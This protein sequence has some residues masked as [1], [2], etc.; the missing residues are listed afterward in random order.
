MSEF[1]LSDVERDD[2]RPAF[3]VRLETFGTR[4]AVVTEGGEAITYAELARRA[5]AAVKDVGRGRRLIALEARNHLD[6]LA[7]YLGALRAGHPLILTS[8]EAD[9]DRIYK[10]FQP[11]VRIVQDGETWRARPTRARAVDVHPDLTLLLSTSGTTGSAKLVRISGV[12]LDSNAD[13]IAEY[14]RLT[15]ADRA[16]TTLPMTYSYGLSVINSH[17]AVGA[18]IILTGTSVTDPDF[19]KLANTHE[20][21]SLAGVPHTY[22][23]LERTGFLNRTPGSL[24]TLTQAGGR[25]PEASVRRFAEWSQAHRIRFYVMYGQTEA[26]ARM[27]YLPPEMT[28]THADAIGVP[29]PGGAFILRDDGGAEVTRAETAGELIY[30]GPNIMMG[31]ASDREDL[32]RGAELTELPTGDLAQRDARGVYRL[33]GRKSRFA[34]IFGLRISLDEIEARIAVSG[35]RGV[36]VSDDNIIVLGLEGDGGGEALIE[37][38]A[39]DYNLPSGIFRATYWDELPRLASGKPDLQSVLRT[40]Q[41]PAPPVGTEHVRPDR[42]IHAAFATAFPRGRPKAD[43]T[44]VSLGGDSLNYVALC[45]ELEDILGFL[46]E[47]W[48]RR[49]LADLC[50]LAPKPR[51]AAWWSLRWIDSEMI[52]RAVAVICV[53]LVHASDLP[54]NGGAEILLL[55]AGY[56]IA[57]Y[58]K[59][60]L[61]GGRG[62]EIVAAFFAR[63]ILPYYALLLLYFA[64][65]GKIDLPSLLLVS[66]FYGRFGSLVEPFWF[67]EALLQCMIIVAALALLPPVRWAVANRPWSSGLVFLAGALA[68]T[69]AVRVFVHDP[70]LA[71]RTPAAVLYLVALGW[72]AHEALGHF[73]RRV[74]VSLAILGIVALGATGAGGYWPKEPEKLLTA[75]TVWYAACGL[76]LLWVRRIPMPTVLHGIVASIAAASFYIYLTHVIPVHFLYWMQRISNPTTIVCASIMLGIAAWW[77]VAKISEYAQ[78]GLGARHRELA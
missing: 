65:K 74:L 59:T 20:A 36:A 22:E 64:A 13:A 2:P 71:G 51:S 78:Q 8:A 39:D 61:A 4:T 16:I 41:A 38:L 7:A 48:E 12:A 72:C 62:F 10:A 9:P 34:K 31:Y 55:L 73:A 6:A 17:L 56:N 76:G 75:H 37:T 1:P 70:S 42:R 14:L 33:V 67:L 53:V 11:Q 30:R 58:Q 19:W 5:D 77:I 63:V 25:L 50:A 60:H 43:D 40:A 23:L 44:F 45:L 26:T 52:L 32:A 54:L 27:A 15:P 49:T 24:R 68:L 66:N 35:R 57:R 69:V 46:P 29:I 28:L 18:S 21:T 3:A 47:Q